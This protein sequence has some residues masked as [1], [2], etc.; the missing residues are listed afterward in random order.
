[1][2]NTQIK[3]I[4]AAATW[5]LRHTVMWPDEPISFVKLARDTVD[6]HHLGLFIGAELVSV[7]SWFG[8]G[9]TAQFR[10][11]ATLSVHQKKGYGSRL[12]QHLIDTLARQGIEKLWC[13]ARVEQISFY[14][15]FGLRSTGK[16]FSKGGRQFVVMSMNIV[17]PKVAQKA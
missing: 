2:Q 5:P 13:N 1:V 3:E 17:V 15:K 8:D 4:P 14:E 12:L 6:G 16:F 11:F 7:I 9:G 10:K